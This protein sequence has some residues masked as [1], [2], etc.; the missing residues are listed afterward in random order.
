MRQDLLDK[1][2]NKDEAISHF[3]LE[4]ER[5]TIKKITKTTP[6]KG[7]TRAAII[8]R[9]KLL[10]ELWD[11]RSPE[12]SFSRDSGKKNNTNRRFIE[13]KKTAA[14]PGVENP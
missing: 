6:T 2:G 11:N 13:V 10:F 4:K 1:I 3:K 7:F 8:F 12:L 5:K 14:N 9:K